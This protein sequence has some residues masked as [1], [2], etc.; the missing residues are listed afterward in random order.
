MNHANKVIGLIFCLI[1]L[2]DT[3]KCRQVRKWHGQRKPPPITVGSDT[4]NG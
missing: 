4:G 3:C 1:I 2:T